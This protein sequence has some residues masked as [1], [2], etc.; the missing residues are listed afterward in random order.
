MRSYR[1]IRNDNP[2]SNQV[3]DLTPDDIALMVKIKRS[4]SSGHDVEVKKDR[5]GNLKLLEVSKKNITAG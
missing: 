3:L 5:D 2:S 4:V 1:T